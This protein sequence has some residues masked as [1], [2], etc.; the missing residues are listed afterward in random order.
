MALQI[1]PIINLIKNSSTIAGTVT[2]LIKQFNKLKEGG[3]NEK[4]FREALE[5]QAALNEKLEKQVILLQ[6]AIFNLQ[7]SLKMLILIIIFAV[8]LSLAA[9]II[10][11]I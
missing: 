7:K 1:L 9:I 10:S 3:I 4:E 8:I 5:L 6:T 11:V 2:S